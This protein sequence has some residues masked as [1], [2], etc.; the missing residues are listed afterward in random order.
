[1]NNFETRELCPACGAAAGETLFSGKFTDQPIVD[2]L[3]GFYS[4]QGMIDISL[5]AGGKYTLVACGE[6]GLVYQ[7]EI[8]NEHLMYVLY[9]KWIDPEYALKLHQCFG[10]EYH[11]KQLREMANV[12]HLLGDIPSKLKCLDFGMGWGL[13]CRMARG[14]GCE[15]HGME[16]SR[17]RIDYAE[18]FGIPNVSYQSINGAEYDFINTEQVFEH[19]PNPLETLIDLKDALSQKG[20]LKISVPDGWNIRKKIRSGLMR[21]ADSFRGELVSIHPLEHINC[22]DYSTLIKMAKKAGLRAISVPDRYAYSFLDAARMFL[23]PWFYALRGS[24]YTRVFL[25]HA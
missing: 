14:F 24:Q 8:L 1:M 17:S 11:L 25:T 23:R 3:L 15:V 12:F 2:F 19:I 20:I 16:L 18:S 5:L 21:K 10:T 9:E 6:C 7:K 22:F 13:W 4:S